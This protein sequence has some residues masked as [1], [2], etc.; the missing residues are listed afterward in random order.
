MHN[1]CAQGYLDEALKRQ[2]LDKVP[3]GGFKETWIEGNYKIEVRVHAGNPKYTNANQIL[4]VSRRPVG[5]G[6]SMIEYLGSDKIWYSIKKLK[7]N[8]F[9]FDPVAAMVTHIPI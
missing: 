8:S 3:E 4:R 9:L 5:M 1:K 2:G 7:P 6:K